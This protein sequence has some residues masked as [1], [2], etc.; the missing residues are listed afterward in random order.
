M[1][2]LLLIVYGAVGLGLLAVTA[3]GV[4]GPLAEVHRV[5]GAM[6]GQRQGIIRA[7]DTTARTLEDA[8]SGLG[9]LDTSL[10]RAHDST[11]Q[12]AFLSRGVAETMR[13]LSAA[14][15]IQIL[16]AQP[17]VGLAASFD[18][19]AVQLEALGGSIDGIATSL[20][21]NSADLQMTR[22]DISDLRTQIQSMTLTLRNGPSL[23]VP[24]AAL[25]GVRLV[26]FG[27]MAWLG[28]LALG[29]TLAGLALVVRSRAPRR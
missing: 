9:R 14:M 4:A 13:Q 1:L 22:R 29:I 21:A 15:N 23:E 16:G 20:D 26:L 12:A 10:A 27:L 19:A 17:F 28:V 11:G 8:G 24:A 18:Q 5:S 7:L 3:A 25:D 6:E 2:G